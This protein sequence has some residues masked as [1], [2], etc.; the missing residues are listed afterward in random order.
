MKQ[1]EILNNRGWLTGLRVLSA[2]LD[3]RDAA[4]YRV[5]PLGVGGRL[6]GAPARLPPGRC[7]PTA[8]LGREGTAQKCSFCLHIARPLGPAHPSRREPGQGLPSP[9]TPPRSPAAHIPPRQRLPSWPSICYLH[10]GSSRGHLFCQ[11]SG[12]SELEPFWISLPTTRLPRECPLAATTKHHKLGGLTGILSRFGRQ[13]IQN[14]GVGRAALWVLPLLFLILAA[15]HGPWLV[16]TLPLLS[17]GPSLCVCAS[18]CPL[19]GHQSLDPGP[20]CLQA[21]SS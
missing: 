7:V 14:Q 17:H 21:A 6:G 20:A 3:P 18:K 8:V 16:V 13:K 9:R 12:Q 1:K 10:G 19:G 15:T 5:C 11:E 2:V 4:Q